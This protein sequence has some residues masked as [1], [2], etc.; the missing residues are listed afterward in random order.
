MRF[1]LLVAAVLVLADLAPSTVAQ[2]RRPQVGLWI[3]TW[4]TKDDQFHHWA[5]CTRLPTIGNDAGRINDNIRAWFDFMDRKPAAA[6]IPIFIAG[7]GE[8]RAG[9]KASQQQAADFN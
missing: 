8:M 1:I 2:E 4:W 6:R 3:S 7:G 5:N 9:G